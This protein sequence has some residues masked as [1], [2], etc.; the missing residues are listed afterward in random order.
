MPPVQAD[1]PPT[2]KARMMQSRG[3]ETPEGPMGML[4]GMTPD[5]VSQM[6]PE[7]AQAMLVQLVTMASQG[8]GGESEEGEE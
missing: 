8:E 5:V 3:G 1:M 7:D 6:A 2:P 4:M